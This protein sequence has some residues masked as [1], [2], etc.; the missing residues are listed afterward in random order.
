ERAIN[1]KVKSSAIVGSTIRTLHPHGDTA[2]YDAMKPM[3]NWFE[4][5]MP[6]LEGKGNWGT[7]FGDGAAAARYTESKLS[8][9]AVECVIG[10]LADNREVLD[11]VEN[12]DGRDEEPEFLAVKVPLLLIN[13]CFGIGYGLRTEVPKHN[14]NEVIDATIKLID[15]PNADI[16]LI[17]DQCM[18]C[19]II[20]SNFKSISNKGHGSF[21]V[22][23]I[24][25]IAEYKG[26]PALIIKTTPDLVYLDKIVEKIE[27]MITDKKLVQIVDMLEDE[28]DKKENKSPNEMK[29]I[30]SLKKGA[31]ANYVRDVIY[32]NTDMEKTFKV[33]FE[34]LDGIDPVRMSYKSYLQSFIEFRKVTKFR[35]Y[36]NH[37][38]DVQTK[39]H[40][41]DAFIKAIQSGYIDEIVNMIRRRTDTNDNDVIEYLVRTLNITDLQASYIINANLKTLSIG[42]LNKYI[43]E[44]NQ[45]YIEEKSLIEKVTIDNIIIDEIRNELLEIK[46]KYG[47]KRKCPI[48]KEADISEIPAG[49]F[50]VVITENNFVKKVPI[51]DTIGSFRQDS[52]KII[53]K[54]D[55]RE[56]LIIFD[57][58]GKVFKLPIHKIPF[59]DRNSN[60]I[61]IR[62]IVKNM[63]SNIIKVL[64]EPVLI[65]FSKR[66]RKYFITI[67]TSDGSIKKLDIEDFLTVPP[68]GILY[69]KLDP[70]DSVKDIALILDTLDIVVYS[71]NKALR[72]NLSEVPHQRR[73]TKGVKSMAEDFVDGLSI[74]KSNTTDI[75]VV[76]EN[77]KINRFDVVALPLL[78]RN[79][80]GSKII[81]LAKGDS[82]KYVAG[83]NV[84]DT[85]R[86]STRNEKVEFKVS[87]IISGSSISSGNKML[88]LKGDNIIRCDIITSK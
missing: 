45:L 18:R 65:E 40:R 84:N 2:I 15:N 64:Y 58:K 66:T 26:R 83:C 27:K 33:N 6:L 28:K 62:T 36:C 9:F 43:A 7:P 14:I 16:T 10:E 19:D 80:S 25:E 59:S 71:K 42:Y 60:G 78:G 35:L 88:A 51:N 73:N 46:A 44:A 52:P 67:L 3:T 22:R 8:D 12:Y 21:K 13:G 85:L 4:I 5:Y 11:W 29:Y 76:T 87:E 68:S 1:K 57:E 20:D 48:I 24:M 30:I 49:D 61:D 74:I 63:T 38:Q 39:L 23:G 54:G 41:K 17:P 32:K 86:V 81:K 50:K 37:L 79:K 82:I 69:I 70:K 75:V 53:V 72:M 55:N 56:S 47:F 77:G 34:A 31:D